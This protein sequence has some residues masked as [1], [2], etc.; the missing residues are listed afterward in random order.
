M[1]QALEGV[2]LS[3]ALAVFPVAGEELDTDPNMRQLDD[4]TVTSIKQSSDLSL[5][6]DASTTLTL[7]Q[8]ERWRVSTLKAMSEI[9]PNFYIPDYGSRMTSSIYVRGLG[10][11]MDQPVVGL[12]IDNVPIL[13][14]DNYDTD[15]FDIERVEVIRGTQSTLYGR[16]TMG[17]QVN[18]YTVRPM[19]YRGNRVMGRI[20][21][22]PEARMAVSSYQEMGRNLYM[23]FVGAMTFSDG[24]YRNHY[25]DTRTGTEKG[26][27]L[28]WRTQWRPASKVLIDN[29]ASFGLSRQGGYPYEEANNRE[30]NYNDTCY[31]RRS[32][33]SDGLTVKWFGE[34][35][36]VASISSIQYLDDEMGLDQDFQPV[37]YFIMK[38]R[39]HEWA[40]TQDVVVRGRAGAYNWT[41]GGFGFFRRTSMWAPVTLKDEGIARLI[42][43]RVNLNDRIPVKLEFDNDHLLLGSDF[44]LPNFGAALYHQSELSLGAW[45]LALGMRLD[46]ERTNMRYHSL[47][48]TSFKAFLKKM[49]SIPILS[50]TIDIDDIGRLH[51]RSLEFLPKFQVSYTLPMPSKSDVYFNVGKGYKSGGFNTQMF[52]EVLQQRLMGEMMQH[53]PGMGG[54]QQQA[55]DIDRITSYKPERSWNYEAGAH[56]ACADGKVMTDLALFYIDCRDQQLTTFPDD[57]TT[58]GRITTNAGRTRSYGLETQIRYA[59]T[60]RWAFN[61]SYGLT[62][63]RFMEYHD[64]DDDFKGKRVPYAP[65]NTLFAGVN[66]IVPAGRDWVLDFNLKCKGVG[67]IYWDNANLYRQNFY[68]QLGASAKAT[69]KWLSFE[70]WGE[71]ITATKFDVFQ[72]ES[73]GYR[74]LQRG[75]PARG[76][77]TV[78]LDF[79]FGRR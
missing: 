39:R 19:H 10:S 59:P 22:G 38:Q 75:K 2:A 41:A 48:G 79:G 58:T 30:I 1:K 20:S 46:Y 9:A 31:Y 74:F 7:K 43:D 57:D 54:S 72:F 76:G 73:L 15:L 53:M 65:S 71:N 8:A 26:L 29:V 35:V 5:L 11:R 32:S 16:N 64:G 56:I 52:S 36:S 34:N 62:N 63:A 40:V 50:Q 51:T 6:P 18:I 21:T 33:L 78:R 68:A 47:G 69:Y 42:T 77:I 60:S 28:R 66:Y 14:K 3:V 49:P 17:G 27:N 23:G 37:N 44:A 70:L 25:N 4:V 67:P 55:P 45:N 61:L 12:N 24:F 13:N